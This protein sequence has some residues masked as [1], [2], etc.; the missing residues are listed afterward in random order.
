MLIPQGQPT[1]VDPRGGT[2]YDARTI[3]ARW[4]RESDIT[5]DVYFRALEAAG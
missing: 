5:D 2:P 4:K 3:G 1:F